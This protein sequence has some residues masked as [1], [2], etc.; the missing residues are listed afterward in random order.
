MDEARTRMLGKLGD[1]RRKSEMKNPL[2]ERDSKPEEMKMNHCFLHQSGLCTL[3]HELV[4]DDG[5]PETATGPC[6]FRGSDVAQLRSCHDG[7]ETSWDVV[8]LT[9]M[10]DLRG[11]GKVASETSHGKK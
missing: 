2:N 3:V 6:F 8:A 5:S 10:T 11:I 7:L 4:V 9:Q 1:I